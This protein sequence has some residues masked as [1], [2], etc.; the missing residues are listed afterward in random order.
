M[1]AT[2]RSTATPRE[3]EKAIADAARASQTPSS[4]SGGVSFASVRGRLGQSAIG[5]PALAL[6]SHLPAVRLL[7]PTWRATSDT[8]SPASMRSTM[9]SRPLGVSLALGCWDMGGSPP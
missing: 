9:R 8:G 6:A 5:S 2:T 4:T 3:A 7:T 1:S